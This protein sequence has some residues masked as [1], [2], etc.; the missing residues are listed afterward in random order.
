MAPP[1]G[2]PAAPAGGRSHS[3]RDRIHYQTDVRLEATEEIYLTPVQRPPDPAEPTSAFLPPAESRM[4]VSSDPDP[5]A[6]P[7]STGRPHPSISEEDEGFDCLS[8]PER[9]EPPA[10]GWRGSLGEPPPPPRASLSSDTSALS[11]DSVKYTLV[12]DEHAQLELVSLRPCF[13]DYSDESDSATVYDNCASASSPYESAIGEEYE[14]A[15]RPRPPTCLSED[16]TP[17]EPD[18]HFSKKFLNVFMSGRSRSSSEWAAGSCRGSWGRC[19]WEAAPGPPGH[20][21][22]AEPWAGTILSQLDSVAYRC[23]VLRALLLRHQRGRAGAD[24]PGHIQVRAEGRLA[25]RSWPHPPGLHR[26]HMA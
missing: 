16:S 15:P 25:G 10:G 12:V 21:I 6:Y 2:P 9:A 8:S 14:E 20:G 22:R 1:G 26:H 19:P 23:R 3:H 7:A 18:V 4:S 11:Y 24:P 13:G 5:A 17:D